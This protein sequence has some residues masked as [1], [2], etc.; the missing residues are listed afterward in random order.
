MDIYQDHILDNPCVC[1]NCFRR[2]SRER[3]HR[4]SRDPTE[5]TSATRSPTTRV[6][7]STTVEHGPA[8]SPSESQGVFCACGA[9]S[10][11]DRLWDGDSLT[12]ERFKTLLV[13][14]VETLGELD[15]TLRRKPT[16][17]LALQ[18][19][20]DGQTVNNA[21]GQAIETGVETA[22]ARPDR[23][24]KTAALAD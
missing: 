1:N 23:E 16:L 8:E 12:D 22:T 20:R 13:A 14:V 9:E 4:E 15:V 17:S 21:L 2:R 10:A 18:Y 5:P 6:R 3:H 24:S 7:A 11:F 19:Y